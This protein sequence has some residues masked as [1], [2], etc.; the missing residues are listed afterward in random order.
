MK[1]KSV[2]KEVA[3]AQKRVFDYNVQVQ[4]SSADLLINESYSAFEVIDFPVWIIFTG[5]LFSETEAE[6]G[7]N[8]ASS[9][10]AVGYMQLVR[11]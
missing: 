10:G 2:G 4:S 6:S 7:A 3:G 5:L 9:S 8:S 11:K 1:V